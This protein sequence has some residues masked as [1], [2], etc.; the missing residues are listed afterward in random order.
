MTVVERD[1]ASAAP[2][3]G[4]AEGLE[5]MRRKGYAV[6]LAED[7]A[8]LRHIRDL[9]VAQASARLGVTAKDA[10][11]FLNRFHEHGLRD[12]EMNEFR[13]NLIQSLSTGTKV[14]E[15]IWQAFRTMLIGLVGP[16]VLVQKATNL[17]IQ[18]PGNSDGTPIHRDAPPNSAFEVVVWLPLVDCYGTKGMRV[19]DIAETQRGVDLQLADVKSQRALEDYVWSH[20]E[21]PAVPFGAALFFWTGL[22]HAVPANSEAE[23]R[24]SLNIRYKNLFSPFGT[25]AMPEHFRILEL[26]PLTRIAMDCKKH[27][28][29]SSAYGTIGRG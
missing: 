27:Q 14:G 23:T 9:V 4:A 29:L 25:K 19:L 1:E 5:S 6:V 18:Q 20:G 8:P 16:D 3:V 7:L 28:V 26:S 13:V 24:W 12:V 15:D 17:V 10:E 11:G 21:N 2:P 22:I